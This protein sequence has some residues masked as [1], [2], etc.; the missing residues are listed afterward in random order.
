MT[1]EPTSAANIDAKGRSRVSH[2]DKLSTSTAPFGRGRQE[3]RCVLDVFQSVELHHGVNHSVVEE[4]T[5][6]SKLKPRRSPT[7]YSIK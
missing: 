3:L 1:R 6:N 4:N 7:F 5:T 2:G